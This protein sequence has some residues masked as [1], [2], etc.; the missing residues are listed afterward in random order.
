MKTRT[1]YMHTLDGKPANY[2]DIRGQQIGYP[3]SRTPIRLVATLRQVRE[4]QA[5]VCTAAHFAGNAEWAN[6]HRYGY[7]RVEVPS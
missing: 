4:Q 3:S 1:M 6:R 5:K 7:V 2:S